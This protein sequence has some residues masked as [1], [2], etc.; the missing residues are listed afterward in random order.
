MKVKKII[1]LLNVL[2]LLIISQNSKAQNI[3]EEPPKV[4][5]ASNV[6]KPLI[7]NIIVLTNYESYFKNYCVNFILK[8][9]KQ[10]KWTKIKIDS[11]KAKINFTEFKIE[12]LYNWLAHYST[13]DL[14]EFI[15]LY[16]NDEKR[17]VKN[18]V[19][20]NPNIAQ[21]L[22]WYAQRLIEN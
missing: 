16:K 22:E 1:S 2:I 10:N 3:Y 13:E 6:N 8:N 7:D 5:M 19:I 14:E 12:I 9:A 21:H 17:K 15:G 18:I 20:N 11:I 4:A